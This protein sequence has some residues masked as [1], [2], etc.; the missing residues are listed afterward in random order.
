MLQGFSKQTEELKSQAGNLTWVLSPK[1]LV[2]TLA[3]IIL[4][5]AV[6][7]IASAYF[8]FADY[9]LPASEWFADLFDL[10]GEFNL[11]AWYQAF[12]LLFSAG[13]LAVIVH[14]KRQ[15][16]DRFLPRWRFL[17]GLFFFFFIDEVFSIH[18]ILII[19]AVREALNLPALFYH[20]WVIPGA[21]LVG[22]F[23]IKYFN[24]FRHLP[25]QFKRLFLLAGSIYVGGALITEMANGVIG[26]I[27]GYTSL[28]NSLLTVV[29]EVL[30]KIGIL[31]WIHAL[32]KYIQGLTQTINIEVHLKG[33]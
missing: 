9:P 19:P 17:A 26:E 7:G 21:I 10:N 28:V 29:E 1:N 5:F 8:E 25:F 6:T 24:F 18:E 27:Y 14:F 16:R 33:R 3:K 2:W 23:C 30:E 11:P 13:L 12:A 15:Q 20:T 22:I 4:F 32:L 31:V